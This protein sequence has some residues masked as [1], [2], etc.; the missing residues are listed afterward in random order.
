V[1]GNIV[2]LCGSRQCSAHTYTTVALFQF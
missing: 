1:S 2:V